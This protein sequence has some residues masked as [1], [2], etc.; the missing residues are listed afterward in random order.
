MNNNKSLPAGRSRKLEK[1]QSEQSDLQAKHA[2]LVSGDDSPNV[3]N[4]FVQYDTEGFNK[5]DIDQIRNYLQHEKKLYLTDD[6]IKD[7]MF[8]VVLHSD[9]VPT[10][11]FTSLDKNINEKKDELISKSNEINTPTQQHELWLLSEKEAVPPNALVFQPEDITIVQEDK[12]RRIKPFASGDVPTEALDNSLNKNGSFTRKKTSDVK[13]ERSAVD[14]IFSKTTVIHKKSVEYVKEPPTI[15]PVKHIE[16]K[17]KEEPNVEYLREEG[18]VSNPRT[19]YSNTFGS[20]DSE[21][22]PSDESKDLCGRVPVQLRNEYDEQSVSYVVEVTKLK[23]S[24]QIQMGKS[25][26]VDKN[27]KKEPLFGVFSIYKNDEKNQCKIT[28]NFYID[29]NTSEQRAAIREVSCDDALNSDL[30]TFCVCLRKSDVDKGNLKCVMMVYK[31]AEYDQDAARDVYVASVKDSK[32]KNSP[33]DKDFTQLNKQFLGIGFVDFN[34]VVSKGKSGTMAIYRETIEDQ[35]DIFQAFDSEKSGK[36]KKMVIEWEM[37]VK[38][39]DKKNEKKKYRLLDPSG[40]DLKTGN[41]KAAILRQIED[42][43]SL[44]DTEFYT[45]YVN[46]VYIYPLEFAVPSKERKRCNFVITVYV[47]ENDEFRVDHD[48]GVFYSTTSVENSFKKS[49]KT[50][51]GSGG[52]SDKFMDEIKAKLPTQLATQNHILF[53][54][55]DVSLDSNGSDDKTVKD[56]KDQSERKTFFATLPF[57]DK[58]KLCGDG[59]YSLPIYNGQPFEG[60][61]SSTYK[62]TVESTDKVKANLKIRLRFMTSVNIQE[63]ALHNFLA[64]VNQT[65][66]TERDGSG[67]NDMERS[68][69][70]ALDDVRMKTPPETLI[71][72]FPYIMQTL[73]TAFQEFKEST[74]VLKYVLAIVECAMKGINSTELRPTVLAQ[75][76]DHYFDRPEKNGRPL[77]SL[78][79]SSLM[80]LFSEIAEFDFQTQKEIQKIRVVSLLKNSW[81]FYELI[82]KSLTM[83]VEANG[84][85]NTASSLKFFRNHI[86]SSDEYTIFSKT[87]IRFVDVHSCVM[88]RIISVATEGDNSYLFNHVF[89]ANAHFALFLTDLMRFFRRNVVLEC[90]DRYISI[91]GSVYDPISS[92][93]F[94]P[95]D[96]D[97]RYAAP[98][99]LFFPKSNAKEQAIED[100]KLAR[101]AAEV[102][103]IDL[104]SIM[105]SFP[106]FV[107][108]SVP[109]VTPTKVNQIQQNLNQYTSLISQRH[110]YANIFSRNILLLLSRSTMTAKYALAVLMKRIMLLDT[111]TRLQTPQT[112]AAISEMFFGVVLYLVEQEKMP[113]AIWSPGNTQFTKIEVENFFIA[114]VWVLK[115]INRNVLSYYFSTETS[116]HISSF[117]EMVKMCLTVLTKKTEA[118][119]DLQDDVN[120]KRETVV[121]SFKREVHQTQVPQTPTKGTSRSTTEHQNSSNSTSVTEKSPKERKKNKHDTTNWEYVKDDVLLVLLD[122]VELAFNGL[123]GRENYLMQILTN[124]ISTTMFKIEMTEHYAKLFLRFIRRLLCSKANYI[125]KENI[126]FGFNLLRSIISLC[127][128]QAY[129]LRQDATSVLYLFAKANYQVTGDTLSSRV[130]AI[131]AIAERDSSNYAILSK[132]IEVLPAWAKLDATAVSQTKVVNKVVEKNTDDSDTKHQQSTLK[133]RKDLIEIIDAER[134]GDGRWWAKKRMLQFLRRR[135]ESSPPTIEAIDQILEKMEESVEKEGR[136]GELRRKATDQAMVILVMFRN[137]T[138]KVALEND[139]TQ[140]MKWQTEQ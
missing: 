117:L 116:A 4:V 107:E 43:T 132:S 87:L 124:L 71:H 58:G 91:V 36:L 49:Q 45:D 100:S 92:T 11:E 109:V 77:F 76:V 66:M 50:C 63:T 104:L 95:N 79:M 32:D 84:Q 60:Y 27:K 65:S 7:L 115:N 102:L 81:F 78:L 105:S 94:T 56:V 138:A 120:F 29:I 13:E 21:F 8:E 93:Y 64:F 22:K 98:N 70:K 114:F 74:N 51:V 136:V 44:Q 118:S 101:Q 1:E 17:E 140:Y 121:L 126:E 96:K 137:I 111:D 14:T 129:E 18:I 73:F 46:N 83:D 48:M 68:I 103:R 5:L 67:R 75:Y 6:Q 9:K 134:G 34:E 2:S 38:P 12:P 28:E 24:D 86:S 135:W 106:Y 69:E 88:R 57:L 42:F 10:T 3:G 30:N 20:L 33:Q 62:T 89:T 99:N 128:N 39:F 108:I 52:K 131:S 125:F 25:T 37:N 15:V 26:A 82:V 110:I 130:F 31:I 113:C 123:F 47:R 40:F 72:H 90:L 19:I 16:P 139:Y 53:V 55:Q 122:V 80:K 127:D 23:V 59:E 85:L 41:S 97:F 133:R 54:I 112:K 61:M 35:K 119:R